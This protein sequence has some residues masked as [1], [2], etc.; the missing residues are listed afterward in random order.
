MKIYLAK[1][2]CIRRKQL[3]FRQLAGKF[4]ANLRI[5]SGQT[6]RTF[7]LHGTTIHQNYF[8]T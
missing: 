7:E 2:L 3:Q 8:S 1:F 6:L 5:P 4:Q